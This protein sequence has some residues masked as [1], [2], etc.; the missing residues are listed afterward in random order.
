MRNIILAM[1]V[2]LNVGCAQAETKVAPIQ[3]TVRE[4]GIGYSSVSTALSDLRN[5]PELA[6][7]IENGWTIANDSKNTT[8]WSFTPEGHPAHPAAVK[9]IVF[10]NDGAVYIDM[11]ALCQADKVSCDRLVSEFE[12]LNELILQSM[13]RRSG[14]SADD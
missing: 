8:I 9:R 6:T 12:E 4:S 13:R 10:E 14:Q 5:R 2:G 7:R 1:L 3:P 11:K